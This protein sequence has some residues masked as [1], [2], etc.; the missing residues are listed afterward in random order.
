MEELALA[1]DYLTTVLLN[2]KRDLEAHINELDSREKAQFAW[3][4]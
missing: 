3:M 1:N 2:H 4:P